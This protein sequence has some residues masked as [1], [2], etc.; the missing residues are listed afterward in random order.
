MIRV[1]MDTNV[2]V[3]AALSQEGNPALIMRMFLLGE[4]KNNITPEI[5]A[6][7]REVLERPKITKKTSL[8]EREFILKAIEEFSEKINPGLTFDEVKEDP[9]DNKILEC[10]V[11]AAA[12]F[13]ISGDGHLLKRIEFRGIKIVSPAEFVKILN[14]K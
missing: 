6:E 9:D 13:I 8:I 12:D 2:I 11:A 1:V 14:L 10:A 3:S 5:I 7:V 4:L